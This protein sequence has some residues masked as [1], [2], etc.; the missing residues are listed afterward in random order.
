MPE[1]ATSEKEDGY[2]QA[3]LL[4]W[5]RVVHKWLHKFDIEDALR[6]WV[7]E[8]AHSKEVVSGRNLDREPLEVR[9]VRPQLTT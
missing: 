7:Q 1:K 6:E 3:I 4:V 2:R 8:T 5:R 9:P